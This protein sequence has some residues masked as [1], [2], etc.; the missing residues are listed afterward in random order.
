MINPAARSCEAAILDLLK[1]PLTY[2]SLLPGF[3]ALATGKK[4]ANSSQK[5]AFFLCFLSFF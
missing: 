3:V 5:V 1:K 2:M 4:E